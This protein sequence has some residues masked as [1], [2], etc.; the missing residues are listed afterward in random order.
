MSLK[1]VFSNESIKSTCRG[2]SAGLA[3]LAGIFCTTKVV[4]LGISSIV[5]GINKADA[6]D[7]Q[8]QD[9]AERFEGKLDDRAKTIGWSAA[10]TLAGAAGYAATRTRKKDN[11]PAL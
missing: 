10:L 9:A 8:S 5:Y 3:L 7:T 2:T 11:K 1:D 4:S 6:Q